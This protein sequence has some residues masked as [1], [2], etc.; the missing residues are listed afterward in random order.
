MKVQERLDAKAERI[1]AKRDA[2]YTGIVLGTLSGAQ[3]LYAANPAGNRIDVYDHNFANV[4]ATTFAG[5][6]VD[7]SLPAGL[8]P[9]NVASI[10]G[11]LFV[12]YTPGNPAVVGLGAINVFDTAG[13]LTGRFATGS[14]TVPLY[15]P[16]GMVQAPSDFGKFSDALL[17]GNFN[18]GNGAASPPAGGPGYILAFDPAPGPNFGKFLGLLQGTDGGPLMI[19]GLWQLIFGNGVSAGKTT[20]LF[21]AAGIQ[22]EQHGLF[23]SLTT[24]GGPTISAVTASPNVLWP[25]NNKFVHVNVGYTVSDNC[26]AAPVCSLSVTATDSGGGINNTASSSIVVDAHSVDWRLPETEEAAAGSTT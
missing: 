19:D 20:D 22:Q 12:S 4:T 23:G 2:A 25:P 5:K 7:S 16:W 21:F 18:L 9:F 26:D 13:N 14:A 24:C 10:G 11:N 1:L 8:V 15:N 3:F 17:V 6:F